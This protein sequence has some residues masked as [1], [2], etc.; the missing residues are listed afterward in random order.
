MEPT[1]FD[2]LLDIVIHLRAPDGCPW[3]RAQDPAT[4]R[5]NLIEEAYE[6]ISAIEE[7]D[8]ENLREELGDLLL[9]ATM[10]AYMKEQE[11]ASGGRG[12]GA[13][14][15]QADPPPPPRVRRA[16]QGHAGPGGRAVEPHQG[17][18]GG[19]EGQALRP[20]ARSRT[21]P[22][23]RGPT[24]SSRRFPRWVSTGPRPARSGRRCRRSWPSCAK[25]HRQKDARRVES[26]LGISFSPP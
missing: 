13:H 1:G 4:L 25:A 6:A 22:R 19:Q 5:G 26:E 12:A 23:W 16:A 15:R 3:D 17:E 9:V 7:G 20:G 10:I 21:L 11:A 14:L 24:R 2:R 18:R 8:D